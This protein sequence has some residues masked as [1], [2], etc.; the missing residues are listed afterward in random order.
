MNWWQNQSNG[1]HHTLL[2]QTFLSKQRESKSYVSSSTQSSVQDHCGKVGP[3]SSQVV[4]SASR[5]W[6]QH[7]GGARL[8]TDIAAVWPSSQQLSAAKELTLGAAI[9]L[10]QGWT[11]LRAL[12]C[13]AL[14]PL[15]WPQES[16]FLPAYGNQ[17]YKQNPDSQIQ[18][19]NGE[20]IAR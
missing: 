7:H 16:G 18:E 4:K 12:R 19:I 5:E 6:G 11:A 9:L 14:D 1:T 8:S 3:R 13:N 2:L 15:S 10:L 20:K 17:Q